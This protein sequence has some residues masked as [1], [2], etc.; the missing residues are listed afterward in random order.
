M[1]YDKT[2]ASAGRSRKTGI[3]SGD[4]SDQ[5]FLYF[6]FV[7]NILKFY[8]AGMKYFPLQDDFI[9]YWGYP[10][11]SISYLFSTVGFFNT[12]PFAGLLDIFFW[13]KFWNFFEI[14]LLIISLLHFSSALIFAKAL[15]KTGIKCGNIFIAVYL[16]TPAGFEAVYWLSAS[17]RIVAGLFFASLAAYAASSEKTGIT[18]FFLL[19]LFAFGF[20]EQITAVCF[21]LCAWIGFYKKRADIFTGNI[22][23]AAVMGIYYA[24]MYDVGALK[25]RAAVNI[26]MYTSLHEI[27][28][29]LSVSSKLFSLGCSPAINSAVI[30]VAVIF[31][32]NASGGNNIKKLYIG[33]LLF[34][35]AL[36]PHI[37][38]GSAHIPLRCIYPGVLGLAA[39]AEYI[40]EKINAGKIFLS[41][42]TVFALSSNIYQAEVFS[43]IG[44]FNIQVC[45]DTAVKDD[46]VYRTV[47]KKFDISVPEWYAEYM[48][49]NI[50]QSGWAFTGAVRAWYKNIALSGI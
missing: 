21:V 43:D 14:S 40:A 2:Y 46:I 3:N 23:A 4:I 39:A 34:F 32:Y 16:L 31:L 41:L 33:A 9:Q 38:S 37:L 26:D 8:A 42:F 13:S 49:E 45:M 30:A 17:T 27:L 6:L 29:S 35:C 28:K 25:G 5:L 7:L 50:S 20:Y 24:I 12:R 36:I 18:E 48:P 1:G 15:E 22:A 10:R 47:R 19:D 11:R 44:K